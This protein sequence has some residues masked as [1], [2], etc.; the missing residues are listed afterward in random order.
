MVYTIDNEINSF[1]S[2][3]EYYLS[4]T[5]KDL[6]EHANEGIVDNNFIATSFLR[7]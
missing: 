3:P 2:E 6:P 1:T 5:L 4:Q 7:H